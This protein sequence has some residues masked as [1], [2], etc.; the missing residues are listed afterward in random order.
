[1][2]LNANAETQLQLNP[3]V[4]VNQPGSQ[5]IVVRADVQVTPGANATGVTLRLYKGGGPGTGVLIA[6]RVCTDPGGGSVGTLDQDT[7]LPAT[8]AVSAQAAGST[9]AGSASGLLESAS[10]NASW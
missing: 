2:A 7:G 4:Q 9:T 3:T 10:A 6:T 8:Y 1:V 5:G